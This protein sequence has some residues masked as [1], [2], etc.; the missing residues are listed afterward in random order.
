MAILRFL[1][2]L[3]ALAAFL[4]CIIINAEEFKIGSL[5]DFQAVEHLAPIETV[6]SKF[7]N[8][9]TGEQFFIKGIAYQ[10]TDPDAIIK[11]DSKYLDPLADSTMCTRDIPR[12][13]ELGINTIRVYSINPELSHD[14]CMEKLVNSGIY[15]LIDLSE[16]DLSIS[17]GQ[18]NWN[19]ETFERYKKVV[20][21]MQG[22]SNVLGFFAGNEVTN[23]ITNTD[24]SPFVKASIR[25]IKEH[26]RNQGYRQIPV[27]YSTNDDI[28]TR[29]NLADYFVC[30]ESSVDFYGINMYEWCGYSSYGSSGYQER[31][32][33]FKDYPVPIFFSEFGCNLV[34]PRPFTEIEALY[35]KHMSKVWSGGLVYMYFEEE[36]DYGVVRIISDTEVEKLEDFDYLQQEF[37]LVNPKGIR[38]EDYAKSVSKH[39]EIHCPNLNDKWKAAKELPPTPDK[40]KCSCLDET[41]PCLAQ[42]LESSE[43]Y[44]EYF[45]YVCGKVDCSDIMADGQN[46]RYGEFADCSTSQK[47][48]LQIS[49]M[50]WQNGGKGR[51]CPI[52]DNSINFNI[53]ASLQGKSECRALVQNVENRF[54]KHLSD[55]NHDKGK[56][57]GAERSA[58]YQSSIFWPVTVFILT[59]ITTLFL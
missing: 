49:K 52:S 40:S 17:R 35:G 44:K 30:G 7:F 20:D 51:T 25:D 54:K 19:V 39:D 15:V 9:E 26:I 38:K 41:L 11:Q 6:G 13:M 57:S 28:D 27:G 16:P 8:S 53:G 58:P 33:E 2:N 43:K 24:A 3:L 32:A 45:D 47:L 42:K 55:K 14:F 50:F 46:G 29:Q 56:T 21:C 37:K 48:A 36:N 1:S 4:T 22:Y 5:Q 34:K 10:P 59:F 23:D 31:T 18:P 12:L